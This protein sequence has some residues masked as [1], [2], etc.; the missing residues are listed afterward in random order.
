MEK[1]TLSY[2]KEEGIVSIDTTQDKILAG[3]ARYLF[4]YIGIGY[5]DV[6][7]KFKND[8]KLYRISERKTGEYVWQEA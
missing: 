4:E 1:A 3:Y 7:V 8:N 2:N 5:P 6:K